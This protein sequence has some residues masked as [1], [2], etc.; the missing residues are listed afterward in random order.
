MTVCNAVPGKF[1]IASLLRARGDSGAG[2]GSA[3]T[4]GEQR[5]LLWESAGEEQ[6]PI[7][8]EW[9]SS[10]WQALT[11]QS[12]PCPSPHH[13]PWPPTPSARQ[14]REKRD[15]SVCSCSLW[16]MR[17]LTH[18]HRSRGLDQM[19]PQVATKLTARKGMFT[20]FAKLL[21]K[22]KQGIQRQ[23]MDLAVV[24]PRAAGAKGLMSLESLWHSMVYGGVP[25]HRGSVCL[26]EWKHLGVALS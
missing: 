14:N 9:P 8:P 15:E 13:C 7:F 3:G 24:T 1:I 18:L 19:A 22:Q 12:P 11:Y 6:G 2:E 10:P 5:E 16:R 23:D 17:I 20:H 4:G 21:K 25:S 26:A